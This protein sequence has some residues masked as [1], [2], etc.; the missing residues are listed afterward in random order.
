MSDNVPSVDTAERRI[1]EIVADYRAARAAGEPYDLDAVLAREPELAE[2]VCARL[3]VGPAGAVTITRIVPPGTPRPGPGTEVETLPQGPPG[4]PVALG[5]F[6][7]YELLE[8]IARGGMGV[9]FRAREKSLDRV[10]A[11]KMILAG[12]LASAE[13]VRRFHLEAERA[14]RLDHPNIVP[15]YRIGEHNGQHYYTMKLIEE[16][17]LGDQDHGPKADLR[18]VARLVA[19]VARAVHHAHR[20][21]ILHR[22]I[23]PGNILIDTDGRPHVADFG[24]AKPL[25]GPPGQT[26]SGA[27]L[28]TPGYISPEQAA[29]RK[30]L[31][32]ATDVYSLGAVLYDLMT[33]R[34][35]FAAPSTLDTLV[36]V[37]EEDPLP[38]H[39]LN[40]RVDR[41]LE[42][43]CLTCLNKDPR[44]RY[45]SAEALAAD[46]ERWL[47]GEPIHARRLGR[48]ERAWKWARRRP[49]DAALVAV[50]GAAALALAGGGWVF[51][52]RL[53]A[54]VHQA[55]EAQAAAEK[56]E[57]EA[58]R[59]RQQVNDYLVYLNERLANLRVEQPVRLE[60]LHEGLALC[61]QFRKGRGE[62][63]EVRRQ[64]ALL[65]GCLG[66]LEQERRDVKKAADAYGRALELLEQ[67]A[68]DFP[69]A[70]LYRNDLA[71]TYAKQANLQEASG[72]HAPAL[73]TLRRAIDVQD[74][75][76]AEPEAPASYRQR[77]AELR[78]TLGTFLEE[79]KKPGEAEA[80]YRAALD[81]MQGLAADAAAPPSSHQQ[82]ALVAGTLAWL[83]AEGNPAEAEGL[84]Q[85][86]LRELRA[87]RTAQPDNRDLTGRLWAGYTDLAAFFR[88][89]GRHAELA[90]L[91]GQVRGDFLGEHEQA[92]QAARFLADA[93]RVAADQNALPAPQRDALTEEYAAAAVAMLDKA[94]KEGF[95]NRARVEV[96]PGLDPLRGRKDFAALM[97]ELERRYPSLSPEQELAAL[98]ALFNQARQTYRYQMDGARTQAERQRA[99]AV[100]P[101]LRA[102]S[103]KL[104]Q[105]ARTWGSAA[106]G[107]E[108]LV[109]VLETC[110]ADEVGPAAAGIRKQAAQLLEQDHFARPEFQDVCV[111][112]ARTPMPELD[113]LLQKALK[114]HPQREVRGLAGLT[115]A[116]NLARAG[117]R[118][119]P[120]DPR[121]AEELM[122]QAET[123]LDRLL[124]DY[125]NV[126]VGRSSLGDIARQD[127]DEVRFLSVGS[128][129]RDVVGE[130][131]NGRPLKL[132]D[133]R[134]QVVVL[135]FWADWC[136]FCR[137]MYPQE[138]D[139][140]ER[141]R[142]KPFALLG[143]NCDEDREAVGH[144]VARKGLTWRSWW[145]GGPDGGRIR[146]DWHVHAFPSIWVLDHK[147]VIRYRGLRGKELDDAVARLVKEAEETQARGK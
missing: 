146:Q 62:D 19:T 138:K 129:A 50:L 105:L 20:H 65:Y 35:P 125:G 76:A 43:V 38:P 23:K 91:A 71:G 135:D 127:L 17:T 113:D 117:V 16:G 122:R 133:F 103:E 98:Q 87:A 144:T 119:R 5:D 10:V 86:G 97:T 2:A 101:D 142:G 74:R 66:D 124:A 93:A 111:R 70:T 51:S 11:L 60:F 14:G 34:P 46:L 116:V 80:A 1:E 55:R 59:K 53:Q 57:Q 30:D 42:T 137:Q 41:D 18:R 141:Y 22:D 61:E 140:V 126:Q 134:D 6:G 115:A 56:G 128:P 40:P 112:A 131:L 72:E 92:Y 69:T 73:A 104:L 120:N 136:G 28:G 67:L 83:L 68:A 114:Q 109:R 145:D 85:R 88:Q 31:T 143:I 12:R 4:C 81:R 47:A 100:Q 13:E 63:A 8:H 44:R 139:L 45:A 36:K 49:L 52:V 7:E 118:A 130:D 99:R 54:A 96:D 95:A 75:L 106:V 84:L 147:H 102:C 78:L 77:A 58:D 48:L 24:L 108:A 37:L 25:S 39:R 121:R 107:Q 90:A 9:V 132:S 3:G 29:A 32:T 26:E 33:G 94:I 27:I 79:Q 110:Q 21:G 82:L 123:A 64:T 89:R 15:I